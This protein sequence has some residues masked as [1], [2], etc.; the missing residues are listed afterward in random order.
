MPRKTVLVIG[1]NGYIGAAVCRAFVRAG[2][3]VFGLVRRQEAA[4]T[5]ALNETIPIV[6]EITDA[7]GIQA[8]L[9]S[10]SKTFDVIVGCIEPPDYE[11][12]IKHAIAA[13][14][15]IA[16]VS[17]AHQ[18]RPLVLWSSGC[19]DYGTTDVDGAP[20]LRPH[21]ETSPLN[22]PGLMVARA[23]CSVKMLEQTDL[24]DAAVLRPT[25]VYGHSSSY[26]GV[27]FEFAAAI[28]ATG[29]KVLTLR[30]INP[31]SIMHAL[32]VDDCAEAYL[33]L[34]EHEDRSAV[35]GQ[36]YN[37]SAAKYETAGQ[38]LKAVAKEYGF[39]EGSKFESG[40]DTTPADESLAPIFGFSQWVGSE[41][42]RGLTG[43]SDRQALFT[44]NLGVY[45]RSYDAA[46]AS[47]HEDLSRVQSRVKS[48]Q[49]KVLWKA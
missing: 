20:G 12:Y 43:W 7:E 21:T 14:R 8:A 32:H 16:K 15:L 35:A 27:I 17:N 39:S 40:V 10:Y 3:I 19:K 48:W 26:F 13:I 33:A 44:E 34:A 28:A 1:A 2:Y 37:I 4:G 25:N 36:C 45:R 41:K 5:L 9:T 30:N 46:V 11:T 22:P 38:V 6:G 23:N 31:N 24:F 29:T 18:V 47:K 49:G 42:I